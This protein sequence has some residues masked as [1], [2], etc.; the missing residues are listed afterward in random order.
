MNWRDGQK[1]GRGNAN[2]KA[3]ASLK[4]ICGF[5]EPQKPIG[6]VAQSLNISEAVIAIPFTKAPVPDITY[7]HTPK[8]GTP[9][10]YLYKLADNKVTDV[11]HSLIHGVHPFTQESGQ[12]Y[13]EAVLSPVADMI[14]KMRK[15]VIPPHL[16]FVGQTLRGGSDTNKGGF[17]KDWT[18]NKGLAI[19]AFP[20]FIF[21]FDHTLDKQELMDIW[22]GI[23][24]YSSIR[25][26]K[27]ASSIT[28][29]LGQSTYDLLPNISLDSH[30]TLT[31]PTDTHWMIF[32]VK[33]RADNNYYN[34]T[35][36]LDAS[37]AG[38]LQIP[39]LMPKTFN[40][41]LGQKLTYSY[42]W[43]YDF[44]TMLELIKLES[45]IDLER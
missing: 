39:G 44:F 40:E 38:F 42:N 34:L 35:P 7:V 33:Q 25:A 15:F 8:W 1:V 30:D 9:P 37:T 16:D 19:D 24:P 31:M 43:P 28:T 3:K 23:M 32:K 2:F 6:Q 4:D 14:N 21:D 13:S 22:Q 5:D 10:M 26:E 29:G 17:V 36:E 27:M 20:M 41:P 18:Q 12:L 45:E 11:M